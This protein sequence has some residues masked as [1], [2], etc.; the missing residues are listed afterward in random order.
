M[1]PFSSQI[2]VKASCQHLDVSCWKND[3]KTKEVKVKKN[4]NFLPQFLFGAFS[5]CAHVD[6]NFRRD[7]LFQ[8]AQNGAAAEGGCVGG[9]G[10]E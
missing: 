4:H 8:S 1:S 9:L 6:L 10:R 7:S 2:F 5:P 3:F